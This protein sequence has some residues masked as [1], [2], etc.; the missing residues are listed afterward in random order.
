MRTKKTFTKPRTQRRLLFQASDH[1][2]HK[3]LAARLSPDLRAS[4]DIKAIPVRNGDTV[5]IMRGDHR[6]FEGKVTRI[7][8]RKYRIYVEGWTREKADG[9]TIFSSIHPSKVMII[10]LNLDDKWRKQVIKR[11]KEAKVQEKVVKAQPLKKDAEKKS[12]E[13]PPKA[14]AKRRRKSTAKITN[15]SETT[16]K[17]TQRNKPRK[18]ASKTKRKSSLKTEGGE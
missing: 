9:T 16:K 10:S 8:K 1:I 18:K 14:K 11:K 13:K 6:G 15:D 12:M 17:T 5:R 4:E 3:H 2:R 7:D